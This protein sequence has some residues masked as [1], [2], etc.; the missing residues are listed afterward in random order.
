M[1]AL[2]VVQTCPYMVFMQDL[3]KENKHHFKVIYAVW[4]RVAS[5]RMACLCVLFV[6]GQ[7]SVVRLLPGPVVLIIPPWMV[8]KI[9]PIN[10]PSD[11]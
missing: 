10:K 4:L 6:F 3:K 5:G 8:Q 11:L 2:K 9:K 7:G 1:W